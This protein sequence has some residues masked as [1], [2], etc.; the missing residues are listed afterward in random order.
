MRLVQTMDPML[1][2]SLPVQIGISG[3]SACLQ[4]DV[5]SGAK[6][7]PQSNFESTAV[8]LGS[9]PECDF[10]L[11]RE[12]FP[13]MYAFLLVD[14]RGAVV[15]HLGGGPSLRLDTK[16]VARHRV[17]KTT[18]ITAGPLAIR[19]HVTPG[20]L[21]LEDP[22]NEFTQRPRNR[23]TIPQ[24]ESGN[25]ALQ[26]EKSIQ[27]IEQASRLL[28]SMGDPEIRFQTPAGMSKDR[29]P[30]CSGDHSPEELNVSVGRPL[31]GQLPPL[32]HHLC[33]N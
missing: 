7:N 14:S 11:D 17:T 12:F 9:D 16:L 27:L 15:R 23:P 8:F 4:I 32:W 5:L 2:Q 3:S 10:I 18:N 25:D 30:L 13:P 28:A 26:I 6:R 1:A 24:N 29:Q 21:S 22:H 19:L 20:P 31:E 33:P